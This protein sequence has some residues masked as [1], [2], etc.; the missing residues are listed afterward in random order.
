MRKAR[1][2]LARPAFRKRYEQADLITGPRAANRSYPS[3]GA[4]STEALGP[5]V[6]PTEAALPSSRGGS[7][8]RATEG[9]SSCRPR[10]GRP[11]T[12]RIVLLSV[13]DPVLVEQDTAEVLDRLSQP[14]P[15]L[16]AL[17]RPGG[18]IVHLSRAAVALVEDASDL[19]TEAALTTTATSSA[20]IVHEEASIPRALA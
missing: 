18:K 16:V 7:V 10:K 1:R 15:L 8:Q 13:A 11:V 9:P 17:T 3:R 4:A 12:T 14:D 6:A 20:S 19:A 5:D 2:K